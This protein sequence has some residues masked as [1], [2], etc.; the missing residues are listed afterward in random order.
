M[1]IDNH[2][3]LQSYVAKKQVSFDVKAAQQRV[4][5]AVQPD[6]QPS[7]SSKNPIPIGEVCKIF[8]HHP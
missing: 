1:V 3:H 7:S 4:G 2:E 5:N 8:W 6:C